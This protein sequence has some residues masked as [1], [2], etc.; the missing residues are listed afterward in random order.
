MMNDGDADDGDDKVGD[1]D[2]DDDDDVDDDDNDMRVMMMMVMMVMMTMMRTNGLSDL[3]KKLQDF[4]SMY[5]SQNCI[6]EGS[7]RGV[8]GSSSDS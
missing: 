4:S 5:L 7:T 6:S 8:Q 2:N 1:D 3:K